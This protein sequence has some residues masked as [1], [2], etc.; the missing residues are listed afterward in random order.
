MR[1]PEEGRKDRAYLL[2]FEE[3]LRGE[4]EQHRSHRFQDN[5]K[6]SFAFS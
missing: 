5:G 2:L 1:A 4:S 3:Q 6:R